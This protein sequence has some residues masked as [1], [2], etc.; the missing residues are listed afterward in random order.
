MRSGRRDFNGPFDML[1]T[2]HFGEV[3]FGFVRR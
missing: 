1:L 3:V 2:T